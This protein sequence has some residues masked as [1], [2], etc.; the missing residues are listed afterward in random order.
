MAQVD[1]EAWDRTRNPWIVLQ[2]I[3]AARLQALAA[4]RPSS[5]ELRT[6]CGHAAPRLSRSAR[7]GFTAHGAGGLARRGLFQ[8]GVRARRG[9]AALCRRALASLPATFSRRRAISASGDRHRSALSRGLFPPDH[10]R[11]RRT[12][13]GL[14][15]QRP[16]H[17][18]RSS[19][20]RA[21]TGPGCAFALDLPGRTVSAARLAGAG[22][23]RQALSLDANDP[24]NSPADRGI[25]GKLYDAGTEIRVMQEIVLG[26]AGWRVV[27]ALAPQVEIC[28]IN[29]G[30]A[31]FAV[32]ERAR[33]YMRRCAACRS[34]RPCGQRA[35]AMSSPPTPRLRRVRPVS[36]RRISLA[37]HARYVDGFLAESGIEL[38]RNVGARA[39]PDPDDASE[40]FNMAYLAMRGSMQSFWRQPAARPRSAGASFSRCFRAGRR[41]RC[42]SATSPTAFMSRAGIPGRRSVSGPTP[43]ARN[44]GAACP[45]PCLN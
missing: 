14:S 28:H 36:G 30:H 38:R 11:R 44:D 20:R 15:V 6:A 23:A 33:A 41:A 37:K 17:R 4:D 18:C 25:T 13:R 27:E 10:R 42:R 8:H 12:A 5:R 1:A 7:A 43:A 29:E 26:I 39:A 40:P 31:A 2:D 45:M 22:R 24:L 19:R 35:P 34:G 21:R 32:L 16:G 3:S 9:I